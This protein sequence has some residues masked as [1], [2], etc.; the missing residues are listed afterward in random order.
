[1]GNRTLLCLILSGMAGALL[2]KTWGVSVENSTLQYIG[3]F[4][5]GAFYA[6]VYG[7]TAMLFTTPYFL[8]SALL[9]AGWTRH[10]RLPQFGPARAGRLPDVVPV[11]KREDL[12]VVIGEV[13]HPTKPIPAEEPHW[14]TIPE[15]GL[16]TGIMIYGAT[17][18]GKTSAA[19][20]P[21]VDQVLGYKAQDKLERPAG[22]LLEVKGDFCHDVR[23]ILER[24]G[25]GN[26]YVALSISGQYG[27]NF[28]YN[29]LMVPR[30]PYEIAYS[31]ATLLNQLFGRGKEPFW[32]QAYT[33]VIGNVIHL[34]KIL[35]DYVTLADVYNACCDE[36]FL[37]AKVLEANK[38]FVGGGI[39]IRHDDYLKIPAGIINHLDWDDDPRAPHMLRVPFAAEIEALLVEQEIPYVI[40]EVSNPNAADRVKRQVLRG[41]NQWYEKEWLG[42]DTKLRTSIL[43]GI[44]SFLQMFAID[45]RLSYIF[46]PP[47]DAYDPLKNVNG[48]FG[49]ILP[50]VRQLIED[51]KVLALDFPM[52]SDPGVSRLIGTLLKQDFQRTM[53]MRITEIKLAPHQTWRSVLFVCDEYHEFAT[54][55]EQDPAGDEKFFPLS[56][57][58]KCIPLVATQSISSLRSTL[59]EDKAW[60]TLAQCFRTKIV[61]SVSDKFTAQWSSEMCGRED[62]LKVNYSLSESGSDARVSVLTGKTVAGKSSMSASK[63]YST[64]KDWRF[65]PKDFTVLKNFQAIVLAYNGQEPLPAMYCYLRPGHWTGNDSWFEYAR[66]GKL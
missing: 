6:I 45:D 16:H 24:H 36:E 54:C 22:L 55:G 52:A 43:A 32:Q 2:H 60:E 30:A 34:F 61:M 14:L 12:E 3:V 63:S 10:L 29:P 57:A 23:Q 37:A 31:I 42:M 28:R 26:D 21:Y 13:H 46:C 18:A 27:E 39:L 15:R 64:Q 56:R 7:W 17:G 1:M 40:S 51:G 20:Y 44:A 38:N 11:E 48:R 65:E 53:L 66:R 9:S 33:H 4:R 47:K 41:V 50:S 19:M 5:P 59:H 35:H 8:L 62:R 25:R 58:A 49:K